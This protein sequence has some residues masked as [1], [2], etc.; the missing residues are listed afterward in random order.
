[1]L[2]ASGH[3][4]CLLWI[5]CRAVYISCKSS[6]SFMSQKCYFI[7]ERLSTRFLDDNSLTRIMLYLQ[8]LLR[9]GMVLTKLTIPQ[10]I[11]ACYFL[12]ATNQYLKNGHSSSSLRKTLTAV[13]KQFN[14]LKAKM[15][16]EVCPRH[17]ER[18]CWGETPDHHMKCFPKWRPVFCELWNLTTSL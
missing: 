13:R 14:L 12:M 15:Q 11:Q 4:F 17:R 2:S 9:V 6:L 16:L 18:I 10:Q 1:M 7:L 8:P 3:W 5:T